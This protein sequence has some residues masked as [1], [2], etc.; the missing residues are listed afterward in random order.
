MKPVT[1][2]R[3][4]NGL[5]L[6]LLCEQRCQWFHFVAVIHPHWCHR[7]QVRWLAGV[8]SLPPKSRMQFDWEKF[9]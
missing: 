2:L 5:K 8:A 3:A 6:V 7:F 9:Q 1:P 4:E